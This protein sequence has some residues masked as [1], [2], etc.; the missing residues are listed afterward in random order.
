MNKSL[1]KNSALLL[2]AILL[3]TS[4]ASIFKGSSADI[5]VNSNP[6]GATVMIN[7]IN[8]GTTPQTMSL[9]RNENYVLTFKKDGYEDVNVEVKK[10]FDVGTTVVGNLFSW[11]LLGLVVDI[12]TGAAYS[13]T[14]ADLQ[15]NFDSMANAGLFD[16]NFKQKEGEI[17]VIMI[18]TEQWEAIQAAK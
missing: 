11:G 8:R 18:T 9:A 1:I 5:R 6:S 17:M 15:A 16:P 12:A 2:F 7:N 14:P 10:K 3:T 4:C 13:L